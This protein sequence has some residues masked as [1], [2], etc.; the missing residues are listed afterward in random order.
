MINQKQP[1]GQPKVM[2]SFA[3]NSSKALKQYAIEQ[4]VLKS[5]DEVNDTQAPNFKAPAIDSPVD[6]E[7]QSLQK[8][9]FNIEA[10]YP[11]FRHSDEI[12]DYTLLKPVQRKSGHAA[13]GEYKFNNIDS[14]SEQKSLKVESESTA[15]SSLQGDRR[16]SPAEFAKQADEETKNEHK[17]ESATSVSAFKGSSFQNYSMFG[18]KA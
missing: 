5:K 17:S 8:T 2:S 4:E 16:D 3:R 7:Y 12:D 15:S 9:Q 13:F 14:T 18:N 1:T 11:K 6:D 10:S